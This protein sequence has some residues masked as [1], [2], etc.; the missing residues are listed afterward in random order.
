MDGVQDAGEAVLEG[1]TVYIYSADGQT[2]IG[3]TQTDENGEWTMTSREFDLEP[4]TPYVLR[5]DLVNDP[6]LA[7]YQ[8]TSGIDES[9]E[10]AS[11]PFDSPPYGEIGSIS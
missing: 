11:F 1:V 4:D 10:T 9:R 7:D 2:L 3:S 6:A 5:Y 8:A